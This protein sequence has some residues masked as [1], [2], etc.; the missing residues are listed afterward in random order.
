[1]LGRSYSP[2]LHEALQ[3][4]KSLHLTNYTVNAPLPIIPRRRFTSI[5]TLVLH[6]ASIE[7]KRIYPL[8]VE[9]K[10][11]DIKPPHI[12][13]RC[14]EPAGEDARSPLLL[15]TGPLTP[16]TTH[17]TV[18]TIFSW[19]TPMAPWIE[20]GGHNSDSWSRFVSVTIVL[21]PSES[22]M[23]NPDPSHGNAPCREVFCNPLGRQ[24]C[25]RSVR[26]IGGEYYGFTSDGNTLISQCPLPPV[27][28]NWGR[29][30]DVR[31]L[32]FKPFAE[33]I[34]EQEPGAIFSTSEAAAFREEDR[35]LVARAKALAPVSLS[36]FPKFKICADSM[37]ETNNMRFIP[38]LSLSEVTRGGRGS[39]IRCI[40]VLQATMY[41]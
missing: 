35:V 30:P 16:F 15:L 12:V 36:K 14:L 24:S 26:F 41:S 23:G 29:P 33:W 39:S 10:L 9:S 34:D 20:I 7:W 31:R 19:D 18:I 17:L 40:I 1:L 25:Y 37:A 32:E 8:K 38:T 5:S 2:F 13:I 28:Q 11:L 27:S 21:L 22:C 3:H 4:V 6:F